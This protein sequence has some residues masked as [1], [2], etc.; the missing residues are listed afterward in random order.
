M[1]ELEVGNGFGGLVGS[2]GDAVAHLHAVDGRT[3]V[4]Y[5]G[6]VVVAGWSEQ[7]VIVFDRVLHSLEE[8]MISKD[9][10]GK[11]LPALFDAVEDRRA[12]HL[13]PCGE[14]HQLIRRRHLLQEF[15][16]IRPQLDIH[17]A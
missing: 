3:E 4:D 15:P 6:V 13:A 7:E 12:V 16:Q 8:Q 17:L 11:V 9:S 14:D 2:D 5:E 1:D 10:M